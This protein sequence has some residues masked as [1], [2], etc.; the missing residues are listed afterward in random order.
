MNMTARWTDSERVKW[1]PHKQIK[2]DLKQEK[3]VNLLY[4]CFLKTISIDRDYMKI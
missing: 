3:T 2:I 4:F 1:K